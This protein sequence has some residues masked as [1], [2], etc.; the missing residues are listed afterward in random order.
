MYNPSYL[1]YPYPPMY[2]YNI[3]EINY[4]ILAQSYYGGIQNYEQRKEK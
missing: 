3:L 1:Q 4:Y 2:N